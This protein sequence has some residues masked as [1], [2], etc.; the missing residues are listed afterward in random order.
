VGSLLVG[1]PDAE[2]LRYVGRVGTGFTD[3]QLAVMRTRLDKLARKTSPLRDVPS[4][5]GR[6]AHWVTPSLVGEVEFAEITADGRLRAPAWR[7]W[8]PD[9]DPSDVI[10]ETPA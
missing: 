7:G 4:T 10:R 5:D 8:R 1:I 2:G 9:K 6:D 3:R